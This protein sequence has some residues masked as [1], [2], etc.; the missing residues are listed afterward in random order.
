MPCKSSTFIP[1]N[2]WSDLACTSYNEGF[3]VNVLE[4][5][6][7]PV[8]G[9][10]WI[11]SITRSEPGLIPGAWQKWPVVEICQNWVD[12]TSYFEFWFHIIY[13]FFLFLSSSV[14]ILTEMSLARLV[15]GK[16]V[17]CLK[18][19]SSLL[20]SNE[21]ISTTVVYWSHYVCPH[22]LIL[23]NQCDHPLQT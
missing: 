23:N 6:V 19:L 21:M 1:Q 4:G 14:L 8:E 13:T 9:F 10:D 20:T 3:T 12:L 7:S 5:D 22:V 16:F 2:S 17:I 11:M 15:T 18:H